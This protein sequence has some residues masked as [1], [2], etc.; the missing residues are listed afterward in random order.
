MGSIYN[1]S[2][3]DSTITVL[4][5]QRPYRIHFNPDLRAYILITR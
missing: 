5:L 3:T 2:N 1:Y 4:A